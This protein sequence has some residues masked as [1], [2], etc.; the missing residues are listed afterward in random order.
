MAGTGGKVLVVVVG[1]FVVVEGKVEDAEASSTVGDE[2]PAAVQ[3]VTTRRHEAM[4]SP[5][6]LGEAIFPFGSHPFCLG[7]APGGTRPFR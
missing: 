3:P 1:G 2:S 6:N 5:I 7:S 4:I